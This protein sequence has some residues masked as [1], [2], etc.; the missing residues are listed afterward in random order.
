MIR[1]DVIELI[2]DRPIAHGV[3][4]AHGESR[5]TVF[6]EIKSVGMKEAYEAMSHGLHPSIVFVLQ[7]SDEYE[8]EHEIIYHGE[9]YKVVR[10]YMVGDGI[11][12]TAER[13]TDDV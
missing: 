4:D 10:T 6:A 3:Y 12:L 11:E 13:V 8:N 2:G 9:R 1:A 7:L 5:R